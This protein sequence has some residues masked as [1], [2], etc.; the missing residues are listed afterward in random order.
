M[1]GANKLS[2]G[3]L[4]GAGSERRE[5]KGRGIGKTARAAHFIFSTNLI[6]YAPVACV[7]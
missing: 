4:R 7:Y 3:S 1:N 6:K 5:P 2:K